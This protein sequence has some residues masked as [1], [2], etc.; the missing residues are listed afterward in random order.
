ML[1]SSK[2]RSRCRKA[3]IFHSTGKLLHRRVRLLFKKDAGFIA[4][5]SCILLVIHFQHQI[6]QIDIKLFNRFRVNEASSRNGISAYREKLRGPLRIDTVRSSDRRLNIPSYL[7]LAKYLKMTKYVKHGPAL[8]NM[9]YG[10]Q[11]NSLHD[12][13]ASNLSDLEQ[14]DKCEQKRDQWFSSRILTTADKNL[15]RLMVRLI[16]F[17]RI[18]S[19]VT[20]PC[21]AEISW[22]F[23]LIDTIRVRLFYS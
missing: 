23:A 1:P 9:A 22:I 13:P 8:H 15:A 14:C 3:D 21:A 17:H 18:R 19:M 5:L 7:P 10:Y 11:K 2:K 20:F 12:M 16:R 6:G 4:V